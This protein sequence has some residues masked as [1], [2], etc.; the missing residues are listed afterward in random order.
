MPPATPGQPD[1][2]TR[3]LEAALTAAADAAPGPVRVADI[4]ARAE[5]SPGHVMYYFQ[6]RDRILT[7]TLLY[8]ESQLATKR[9]I[10][11]AKSPNAAHAMEQLVRL[12]LPRNRADPRWRLWTQVLAN[13][14]EDAETRTAIGSTIDAWS[15]ALATV[16]RNGCAEGS[17]ACEDPDQTAYQTCRLMDGYGL[18]VLLG[19][20]GRS[21]AWALRSVLAALPQTL[22][23]PP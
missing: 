10:Q 2:R 16:I 5:M 14:P 21:R 8:A 12:Y 3:V 11:L 22:S 23:P 20:P 19:G 18:E 17:M 13:A 9:D 15:A 1:A 6:R 7:E 4:A